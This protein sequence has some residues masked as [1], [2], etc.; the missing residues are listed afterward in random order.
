MAR[1]IKLTAEDFCLFESLHIKLAN[2][3]LVFIGGEDHD[4]DAADSN[5]S[6]KS[7][8]F[9]ALSW[10]LFGKTIDEEEG[11]KVIRNGQKCAR[12]ITDMED[13]D[14]TYRIVRERRKQSPKLYVY[15]NGN[16]KPEDKS[17]VDLQ[18]L[19]NRLVGVDWDGF[20]NTVLYGQN[21]RE[22]FIYPKTKDSTRKDILHRILRTG[23]FAFCYEEAK[24]RNR[25]LKKQEGDLAT[26]IENIGDRIDDFDFDDLQARVD[27]HAEETKERIRE[28]TAEGTDLA[29]QAK[30]AKGGKTPRVIQAL[31]DV[32]VTE[33]EVLARTIKETKTSRD[34]ADDRVYDEG[35][36]T[37]ALDEN[38]KDVVASLKLLK[39]KQCPTCTGPLVKGHGFAHIRTL[40]A[41][42][43]SIDADIT[44]AKE[45]RQKAAQTRQ[46]HKTALT[47]H[48]VERD[49]LTALQATR[50]TD[51]AEAR[52][53]ATRAADLADQARA[54]A[55][56]ARAARGQDNPHQIAL[57]QAREKV[58][59]LKQRR[60]A[61]RAELEAAS[62][63]RSA[64]EFWT[65]GFGPSGL[66]SF[67][68]DATMPY[69][70]ERANHYLE[71]LS[72][73]DITI[74]FSTQREL[75]SAAGEFRDEIAITWTV[76]GVDD[77]PPSGGQFKKMEIAT[78][79][80]MMDLVA[81]RESSHVSVLCLDECLDGLDTQGRLR[82]IKLLH[83]L[84]S[85]RETIFVI[86]HDQ[87]LGEI[88]EKSLLVVKEDGVSHLEDA[89]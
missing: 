67:V 14:D 33:L 26:E 57:T 75:K 15:K 66:P 68:L 79:L 81:T 55:D 1:L 2:Q 59:K 56:E 87:D 48:E 18:L 13:D 84:R 64:V 32:T 70:T 58:A 23:I 4:T 37:S 30:A 16:D 36:R 7:T 25:D 60:K 22:R 50:A 76:E 27:D 52:A 9:K 63:K 6:G 12:V 77:Y 5:G 78:D 45:A 88:F 51:L 62:L 19:I 86:S 47:S 24:N 89:A 8:I 20:R 29:A 10:G 38:R 31:I 11:D 71:T 82:I 74:S 41:R 72:D 69:L 39:G 65:R 42:Q 43:A 17:K 21:D 49:H 34:F 44:D 85:T 73:G 3:G 61:A 40:K 54:K 53:A 46:R 83:D 80:A 28:L 35:R